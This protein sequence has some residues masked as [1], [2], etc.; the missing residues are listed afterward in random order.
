M[1]G[2]SSVCRRRTCIVAVAERLR[3]VWMT[4]QRCCVCNNNRAK[5]PAVSFHRIPRN[6]ATRAKWLEV[7]N[8]TENAIKPSSRVCSRHFPDGDVKKDPSMTVGKFI[9]Y[10]LPSMKSTWV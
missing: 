2:V 6:K 5:D 10:T 9:S 8:L 1:A 4:G 7:F 3:A